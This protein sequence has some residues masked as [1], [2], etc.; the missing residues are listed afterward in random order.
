MKK[1]V[2]LAAFS[3]AI[4][5]VSA[6]D[7]VYDW[8]SWTTDPAQVVE[9]DDNSVKVVLFTNPTGNLAIGTKNDQ[10]GMGEMFD[11]DPATYVAYGQ[12]NYFIPLPCNSLI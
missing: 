12:S 7:V 3:T 8:G 1:F 9:S 4:A 2:A 6:A 10:G 11:G 5:A